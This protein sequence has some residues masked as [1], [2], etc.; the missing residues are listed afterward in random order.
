MFVV[1]TAAAAVAMA[2]MWDVLDA[3][4]AGSQAAPSPLIETD[5]TAPEPRLENTPNEVRARLDA[6]REMQ[7]STYTWVDRQGGVARIPVERAMELLTE[8]GLPYRGA[9]EV[10]E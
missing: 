1:V 6:L 8:R 2:L 9:A 5:I 7:A 4:V 10:Q 3:R